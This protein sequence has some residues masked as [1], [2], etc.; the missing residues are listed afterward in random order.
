MEAI[1]AITREPNAPFSI[2]T[3]EIASPSA[4]EVRVRIHAVGICHT[5]LVFA[6]GAM[7]S[8]FPIVLG[9][10]GAGVVEAVGAGVAK[11]AVG[12]KVL[13][14]FDSCGQCPTCESHDPAYCQ[15]FV[16]LN[17]AGVYSDGSSP[18]SQ[19]GSAV[20]GRFFGQSS[21]ANYAIA[22]V[23]NV[24]KL[25]AD[26][27][28]AAL[29]PLGCGVQTGIGAVMRSLAAKPGSSLVIIGG[30]AVG[31]SAII[32]GVL[33]GCTTII[34]IEP[35]A[36]RRAIALS[37]GAHHA[38]DPTSR[39]TTE[40][41][42]AILPHGANNIIDT[43]GHAGALQA[44]IGMLAQKG[45]LGLIGVPGALDEAL[46][47]PI[48]PALTLGFSVMGICEGDSDP[49]EFLPELVE[50]FAAGRLPI[51]KFTHI[52]PFDQINQAIDD[53]HHGRCVKAVLVFDN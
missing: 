18:L 29:A 27:N 22:S 37:I 31:L 3:V 40:A 44:T 47:V 17:F 46:A 1:A 15:N 38:L 52:Y 12:D 6:S 20:S 34:M 11:V 4:H 13:L 2:E 5:D 45:K 19:N 28:L 33:A 7:G 42:R 53:A 48:V 10:E 36:E 50:H 26:A 21:F 35:Q 32:G 24:V 30:G 49:D 14:T 43:S 41:V 16:P 8:P 25:P 51:D 23:R 39:D 9:H